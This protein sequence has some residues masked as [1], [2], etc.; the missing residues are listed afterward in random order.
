[1][2]SI[3]LVQFVRHEIK[4]CE[5]EKRCAEKRFSNFR[6]RLPT[7]TL[8]ELR[9]KL[10]EETMPGYPC[11]FHGC[12]K[13]AYAKVDKHWSDVRRSHQIAMAALPSCGD[14]AH[15]R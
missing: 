5:F 15:C 6:R 3:R 8:V 13:E 10:E 11:S 1:M 7:T 12:G 14:G 2:N 9:K 4:N